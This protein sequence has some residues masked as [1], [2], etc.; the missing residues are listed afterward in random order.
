MSGGGDFFN[1]IEMSGLL[2]FVDSESQFF[3]APY[4]RYSS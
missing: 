2:A 1:V 3:G 4:V